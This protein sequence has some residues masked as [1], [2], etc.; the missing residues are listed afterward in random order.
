MDIE[1]FANQINIKIKS[2]RK[3]IIIIFKHNW[4]IRL[5]ILIF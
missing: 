5:I 2:K 3:F 1:L 4:N